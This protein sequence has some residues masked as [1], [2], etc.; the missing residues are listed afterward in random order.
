MPHTAT[1]IARAVRGGD[2]PWSASAEAALAALYESQPSL[3]TAITL[4]EELPTPPSVEQLR[5]APLAGV[6]V[7]VKDL[8]DTAR[9]RTTYGSAIFRDRVPATSA[10]CVQRLVAAGAV[11]VGKA[12][13][14][15]FAWG[16]TSRNPTWC[17]VVNPRDPT[18]TPGGSSGGNAAAVAAGLVPLGIGT[19]TGGSVRVPA[20]CCDVVGFKPSNGAVSTQGVFALARSLDCVGPIAGSVADCVL[21][22]TVLTGQPLPARAIGELRVAA[23]G[24]QLVATL[25]ECGVSAIP[26]RRP[27]APVEASAILPF[28]AWQVHRDLVERR[29]DSYDPNVLAKLRGAQRVEPGDYERAVAAVIAWRA[30]T[31]AEVGYDV[32]VDHTLDIAVPAA[33]VD[34]IAVREEFGRAVRWVNQLG[35]GSVAVGPIQVAGP[36]DASVLAVAAVLEPAVSLPPAGARR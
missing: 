34:E 15:E 23:T 35:W 18:L 9:L 28:E 1:A 6:P 30:A 11:V 25:R 5:H 7:L 16:L 27:A 21:A 20:A 12:N 14:H 29:A 36:D 22:F 26:A 32:L 10:E 2:L 17:D 3:H 8:I 4:V 13:L 24:P 33:D 31:A 19:D